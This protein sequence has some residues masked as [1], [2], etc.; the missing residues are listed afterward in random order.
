MATFDKTDIRHQGAYTR[1]EAALPFKLPQA[2]LARGP[3]AA[4]IP[5]PKGRTASGADQPAR[6]KPPLLSFFNLIEAHVPA[7]LVHGARVDQGLARFRL[8]FAERKL[9]IDRLFARKTFCTYGGKVLLDH[10]QPADRGF[11]SSWAKIAIRVVG[12]H[13]GPLRWDAVEVPGAPVSVPDGGTLDG[14]RPIAI[15]VKSSP[16]GRPVLVAQVRCSTPHRRNVWTP[17][18]RSMIWLP[19]TT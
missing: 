13:L 8:P 14:R 2:T 12:D 6:G 10:F 9:A 1:P 5:W 3:S 11:S 4:T 7:A 19:T 16:S 15:D 18:S 17:A